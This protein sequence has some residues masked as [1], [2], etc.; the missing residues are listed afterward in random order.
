MANLDIE[1]KTVRFDLDFKDRGPK[2]AAVEIW[3]I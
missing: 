2:G 1:F 3:Q